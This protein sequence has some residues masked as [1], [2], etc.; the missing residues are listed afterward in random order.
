V[1]ELYGFAWRFDGH[2]YSKRRVT[3]EIE[4]FKGTRS[5]ASLPAMELSPLFERMLE[6]DQYLITSTY[7][8]HHS[9]QI[10]DEFTRLS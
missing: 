10:A 6:G 7:T 5:I 8:A 9:F 2:G 3:R 4:Q 1:L